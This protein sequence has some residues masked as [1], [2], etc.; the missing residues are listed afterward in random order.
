MVYD[1]NYALNNRIHIKSEQ[2]GIQ[3]LFD[4]YII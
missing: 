2:L 3:M 1:Q 4:F